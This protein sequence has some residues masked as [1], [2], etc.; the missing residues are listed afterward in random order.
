MRFGR[1][2]PAARRRGASSATATLII[3][4]V[5]VEIAAAN[6]IA[7]P[8]IKTLLR[9]LGVY[10]CSAGPF[11]N[12]RPR[13]QSASRLD[14]RGAAYAGAGSLIVVVIIVAMLP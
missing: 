13:V 12:P 8:P 11:N 10:P 1:E 2:R 3:N 7:F 9:P 14:G 4:A 6:L 5:H